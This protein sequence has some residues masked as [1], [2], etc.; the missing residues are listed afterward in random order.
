[1]LSLSECTSIS[2]KT[3]LEPDTLNA[4]RFKPEYFTRNR[5]FP[6]QSVLKYLISLRKGSAQHTLNDFFDVEGEKAVSQ[7]ALSKARSKFSALPFQKVFEAIV[8]TSYDDEHI[9]DLQRFN[10]KFLIAIDGSTVTLPNIPELGRIFGTMSN[11]PKARAS[12]AYDVLNDLVIDADI[13]EI[14]CGEGLQAS[15][16]I[17]NIEEI[18]NL[19]EAIFIFDRGYPSRYLIDRLYDKSNF[20]M[21]LKTK[22]NKEIDALGIGSHIITPYYDDQPIRVIK[23]Q[24]NSGEIETL[25]TNLFDLDEADFKELYFKRWPVETKYDIVKN[26][27]EL[28]NFTGFTENVIYQDFWISMYMVN[29]AAVAKYESDILVH[30]E[31]AHKNNKYQYQTNVN[32]L[33]GTLRGKFANAVFFATEEERNKIIQDIIQKIKRAVVP[34]NRDSSKVRRG[35][36]R[37]TKYHH[38]RK[39]NL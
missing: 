29:I 37:I 19:K 12:I 35:K 20:L 25:I 26:K 28:P 18:I 9:S 34:T 15:C 10:G 38:N 3:F 16:H 7:Q 8:K 5:K 24:L 27:L 1:M 11:S 21:R 2:K 17:Y 33:I 13:D 30:E 6:F 14:S 32:N 23:L 36:K 4:S 31:R 39:S 22:F